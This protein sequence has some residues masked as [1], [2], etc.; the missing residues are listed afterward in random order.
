MVMLLASAEETSLQ[1]KTE[2]FSEDMESE[3]AVWEP[4]PAIL[5]PVHEVMVWYGSR[6]WELL[7]QP[8]ELPH[9]QQSLIP[10]KQLR[11]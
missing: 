7:K 4:F 2:L 5:I 1:S 9:A 3:T 6:V 8:D 10:R 11:L